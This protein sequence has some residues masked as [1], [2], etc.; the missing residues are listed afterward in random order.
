MRF[1]ILFSAFGDCG[2]F[3]ST[4]DVSNE[5]R[6]NC[7]NQKPYDIEV[8]NRKSCVSSER[9]RSSPPPAPRGIT[10]SSASAMMSDD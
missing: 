5:V 6:L 4:I 10:S 2:V 7:V 1:E 9:S 8:K 3:F